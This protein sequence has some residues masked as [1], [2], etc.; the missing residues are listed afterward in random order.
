MRFFNVYLG[1]YR[2]IPVIV[3]KVLCVD[4]WGQKLYSLFQEEAIKIRY[5]V[6]MM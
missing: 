2:D 5:D 6:I 4:G 1:T 3:K